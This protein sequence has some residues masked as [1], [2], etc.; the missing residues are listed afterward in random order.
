MNHNSLIQLIKQLIKPNYFVIFLTDEAPQFLQKLTPLFIYCFIHLLLC[1]AF[2]SVTTPLISS[3]HAFS[4][5]CFIWDAIIWNSE[6]WCHNIQCIIYLANAGTANKLRCGN[7]PSYSV[8]YPRKM[9]LD[10]HLMLTV[11]LLSSHVLPIFSEDH[12]NISEHFWIFRKISKGCGSPLRNV[13][14]SFNLVSRTLDSL[15]NVI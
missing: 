5:S 8:I 14:K 10:P 9:K 15:K 11:V 1:L 7:D 6:L 13:R 3:L 12:T 2:V 4:L